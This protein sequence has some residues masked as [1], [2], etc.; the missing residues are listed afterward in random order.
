MGLIAAVLEGME[1]STCG[2]HFSTSSRSPMLQGVYSV[3][4]SQ[5]TVYLLG[6]AYRAGEQG[7][8]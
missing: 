3:C 4:L 2:R 8:V 7:R 6:E 5:Y 1:V